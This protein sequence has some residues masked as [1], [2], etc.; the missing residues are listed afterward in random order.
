MAER[1]V[2]DLE[3][4]EI[5]EQDREFAHP[6]LVG[7]AADLIERRAK[8]AAVRETGQRIL[9]GEPR[10]MRFRLAPLGDVGE[11]LN[12]AAVG[13]MPAAHLDH[14]AIRHGPLADRDLP[15]GSA[16]RGAIS[17]QCGLRLGVRG[18]SVPRLKRHQLV[19]PRRMLDEL[20]G[21]IEE[22]AAPAVDDRDLQVLGDQHD[23]L[24]HVLER[25]LELVR[26][27]PRLRLGSQDLLDRAEDDQRECRG[28]K[29]I[30]LQVRPR[31]LIDLVFVGS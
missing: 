11:G 14:G 13:E 18:L 31:A 10:D 20:R 29:H 17:R 5:E 4:V 1:V 2:D 21:Q 24:A 16:G 26:L 30:D 19:E 22:L 9:G 23:A 27:L 7:A 3:A 12:E 28:R 25:E 15:R 6:T 8:D